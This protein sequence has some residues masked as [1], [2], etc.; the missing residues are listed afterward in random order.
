MCFWFPITFIHISLPYEYLATYGQKCILSQV[1]W[2]LKQIKVKKFSF[3]H[4]FT[5]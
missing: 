3:T 5:T 1:M 4:N 2:A